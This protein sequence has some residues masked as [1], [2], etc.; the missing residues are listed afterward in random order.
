MHSLS[1]AEELFRGR[2][3]LEASE[4]LGNTKG[5]G[6]W[7]GWRG[8]AASARSLEE[9]PAPSAPGTCL[10]GRRSVSSPGPASSTPPHQPRAYSGAPGGLGGLGAAGGSAW[11]G[12]SWGGGWRELLPLGRGGLRA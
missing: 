10:C 11:S 6:G 12:G 3:E 1:A 8:R 2:V 9:W 5:G 4:T 7:K